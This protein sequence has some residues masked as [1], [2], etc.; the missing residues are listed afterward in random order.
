MTAIPT[1]LNSITNLIDEAH[2]AKRQTPR[3]HLGCSML[4]H[5]CERYLWLSFRWAVIEQFNG[6]ILRLFRRGHN[7]EATIIADLEMIGVKVTGTQDRVDFGCHVSGSIDGLLDNVPEAPKTTH[8]AEFKTH[9][10]KSFAGLLK[11]GLLKSKPIHFAQMQVYLLGKG[12]TRGLYF[13]VEKDTDTLYTE[14]VKFDEDAATKLVDRGRRIALTER[15]PPPISSDPSWYQCK[16]C[17]GHSLCHVTKLTKEVN[18][19]TCAL[20][21]PL[22]NSTWH[23]SK[24]D[25]E[26]PFK[27]QLEGCEGHVLHPDLVPW[28]WVGENGDSNTYKIAGVE[29]VNGEGGVKSKDLVCD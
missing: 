20:S 23:C 6:R 1:P 17:P 7:E 19:R 3:A 29:I 21:T 9:S 22:A 4:G 28:D 18:C 14:R 13:A 2:A 15:M 16:F 8:L 5:H 27:V 24:W 11:D 10:K 25:A 12:L 26:I